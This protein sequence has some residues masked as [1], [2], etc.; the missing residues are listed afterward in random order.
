MAHCICDWALAHASPLVA[1]Q[2]QSGNLFYANV[3]ESPA[4]A[5]YGKVAD[6][7]VQLYANVATTS[8]AP[9]IPRAERDLSMLPPPAPLPM[10]VAS[11]AQK[12]PECALDPPPS[13]TAKRV[14]LARL[15]AEH[16]D[17]Y[18]TSLP[19]R[20]SYFAK[21]ILVPL[22]VHDAWYACQV[23]SVGSLKCI[24]AALIASDVCKTRLPTHIAIFYQRAGLSARTA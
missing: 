7:A 17:T 12:K 19:D 22:T 21:V 5:A 9:H 2:P 14:W 10:A 23:S 3:D 18:Y 1:E 24:L 15:R 6:P 4:A 20:T 13:D 8:G 11:E 16:D